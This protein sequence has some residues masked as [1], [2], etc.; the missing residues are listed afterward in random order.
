[1]TSSEPRRR[2]DI[3]AQDREKSMS[4]LDKDQLK[5][6]CLERVR[7]ERSR[8]MARMRGRR[9]L[10]GGSEL[11]DGIGGSDSS[12][13]P[14]A[15]AAA[16]ADGEGQNTAFSPGQNS[17]SSAR[18]ILRHGLSE[19]S[20]GNGTRKRPRGQGEHPDPDHKHQTPS[21]QLLES[22]ASESSPGRRGVGTGPWSSSFLSAIE[23]ENAS[24]RQA[25]SGRRGSRQ[26]LQP[27]AVE[28]INPGGSDAPGDARTPASTRIR[29]QTQGLGEGGSD[30]G[31]DMVDDGREGESTLQQPQQKRQQ[32]QQ[33]QQ[34]AEAM[35]EGDEPVWDDGYRDEEHLLSREEYLEMMQ[36]IEEACK[37]EDLRAEA[38]ALEEYEMTKRLE[39]E[40]VEYAVSS[41]LDGV[42]CNGQDENTVLCP[43]CKRNYLLQGAQP[44]GSIFCAC[45]FRLDTGGD[46]LG[47]EHLKEQLAETYSQ[48]SAACSAE[49]TFVVEGAP[50][51][52][53]L[54]SSCDVCGFARVVL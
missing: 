28:S 54:W 43:V 50:G 38:E 53:V 15:S 14:S 25:C 8:L 6:R 27:P 26:E 12:L 17:L 30:G 18:E 52:D 3:K 47:L 20:G 13:T 40:E 10:E 46:R 31:G 29:E 42:G 44:S 5:R 34:E 49:P 22:R 39:E 37:E 2:R 32:Q 1:M 9:G 41:C 45:G 11:S 7:S 48:H 23:E 4:P 21:P 36:Y 51:L 35:V 33:Q 16:A 24:Y 19:L